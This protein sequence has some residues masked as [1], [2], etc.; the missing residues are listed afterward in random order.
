M[1]F[2]VLSK[3]LEHIAVPLPPVGI[4]DGVRTGPD[5]GRPHLYGEHLYESNHEVH[6]GYSL[7]SHRQT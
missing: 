7:M 2:T 4:E 5:C 3:Y 1:Q 6:Q